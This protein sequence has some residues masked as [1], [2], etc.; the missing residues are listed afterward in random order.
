M[1]PI[2]MALILAAN[3]H[4]SYEVVH[5]VEVN[6]FHD[7]AGKP[8]YT[9]VIFYEDFHGKWLVRHWM[10]LSPKDPITKHP[11]GERNSVRWFDADKHVFRRIDA[12]IYAETYTHHDPERDNQKILPIDQRVQLCNPD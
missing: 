2:I 8:V 5:A 9:Q 12:K 6:H 10:L 4:Q 1:I 3:P 11:S 7:E